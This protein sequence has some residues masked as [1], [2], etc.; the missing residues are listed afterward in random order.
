MG[1]EKTAQAEEWMQ[2]MMSAFTEEGLG[3]GGQEQQQ[4]PQGE[5]TTVARPEDVTTEDVREREQQQQQQN[6]QQQQ[7]GQGQQGRPTP[8]KDRQK[9]LNKVEKRA[10]ENFEDLREEF[11][12]K[13]PQSFGESVDAFA[14]EEVKWIDTG[15]GRIRVNNARELALGLQKSPRDVERAVGRKLEAQLL[16]QELTEDQKKGQQKSK[17]LQQLMKLAQNRM[18]NAQKQKNQLR[19]EA[20]QRG[21]QAQDRREFRLTEQRLRAK[22]QRKRQEAASDEEASQRSQMITSV[23]NSAI[24]NQKG[25]V[26]TDVIKNIAKRFPA[27]GQQEVKEVAINRVRE[28]LRERQKKRGAPLSRDERERLLNMVGGAVDEGRKEQQKKNFR[29][30]EVGDIEKEDGRVTGVETKIKGTN[31]T[32]KDW[33]KILKA[34]D[35]LATQSGLTSKQ[36]LSVVRS[37]LR[38]FQQNLG[39]LRSL[40]PAQIVDR[41][42]SSDVLE[43]VKSMSKQAVTE[44]KNATGPVHGALSSLRKKYQSSVQQEFLGSKSPAGKGLKIV[45]RILA[46]LWKQK[47]HSIATDDN[48]VFGFNQIGDKL[49]KS[50]R[51]TWDQVKQR[52]AEKQNEFQSAIEKLNKAIQ[53]EDQNFLVDAIE[54]GGAAFAGAAK[55]I[56]E[57]RG[58]FE[59]LGSAGPASPAIRAI[60]G[61]SEEIQKLSESE[62]LQRART[63]KTLLQTHKQVYK[64]IR[65]D[66]TNSLDITENQQ[67]LLNRTYNDPS[68]MMNPIRFQIMKEMNN[69]V[70]QG[71]AM[72]SGL[73]V[74]DAIQGETSFR[75]KLPGDQ[76]THAVG[77]DL[78]KRFRWGNIERR[79]QSQASTTEGVSLIK[80]AYKTLWDG[81]KTADFLRRAREKGRAIQGIDP[82]RVN[83][84]NESQLEVISAQFIPTDSDFLRGSREVLKNL[85][86]AKNAIE[87]RVLNTQ[88]QVGRLP[89]QIQGTVQSIVQKA[90]KKANPVKYIN[91]IFDDLRRALEGVTNSLMVGLDQVASN[92]VPN[93]Q[94]IEDDLIRMGKAGE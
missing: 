51:G 16:Q 67:K 66:D 5:H 90:G 88:E 21:K 8:F 62:K 14:K 68:Q 82:N 18:Q 69:T 4:R 37:V 81:E 85:L 3:G 1:D 38:P 58:A 45:E 26:N 77:G 44:A 63:I 52:I 17:Q 36:S 61:G 86:N 33:R 20:R 19:E 15:D 27:I 72:K 73:K 93:Y 25:G 32:N 59:S 34:G 13:D 40:E 49:S 78:R 12:K 31:L 10:R 89:D 48:D 79:A 35:K 84:N 65:N 22:E 29:R 80:N 47:E 54:M 7:Q 60:K 50:E 57:E 92:S 42:Q 94:N 2:E 41:V 9:K 64:A 43:N 55:S 6:Q 91:Q 83:S 24:L 71:N 46:P 70:F 76:D 56:T 23:N 39:E 53:S 75:G 30:K 74:A 11:Q 87:A 28:Q